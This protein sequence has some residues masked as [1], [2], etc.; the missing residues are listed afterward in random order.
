[1][2]SILYHPWCSNLP[3]FFLRRDI[4]QM[5]WH[6]DMSCMP[7]YLLAVVFHDRSDGAGLCIFPQCWMTRWT[8]NWCLRV[9][10]ESRSLTHNSTGKEDIS[11]HLKQSSRHPITYVFLACITLNLL[12]AQH[13]IFVSTPKETCIQHTEVRRKKQI[14]FTSAMLSRWKCRLAWGCILVVG[15]LV[16]R[17]RFFLE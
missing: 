12:L 3:H 16:T 2:G 1:M 15:A 9:V 7:W 11:Y 5:Q 8:R 17:K 10:Q 14:C 13:N 4:L 6:D